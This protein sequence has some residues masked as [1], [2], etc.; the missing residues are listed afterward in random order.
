MLVNQAIATMVLVV[1]LCAMLT[2]PM[3]QLQLLHASLYT[4]AVARVSVDTSTTTMTLAL[5][6][7][8]VTLQWVNTS[9]S[10]TM[11]DTLKSVKTTVVKLPVLKETACL[12]V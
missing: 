7:V 1:D 9:S 12:F 8:I 11:P 10:I 2:C 4:T 3:R 6:S 5:T